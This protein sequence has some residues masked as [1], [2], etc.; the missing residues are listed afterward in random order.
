MVDY[1]A[2]LLCVKRPLLKIVVHSE[3]LERATHFEADNLGC[4]QPSSSK[5]GEAQQNFIVL[6]IPLHILKAVWREVARSS[7]QG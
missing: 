6:I 7:L 1:L 2:E 3:V 5:D 4:V